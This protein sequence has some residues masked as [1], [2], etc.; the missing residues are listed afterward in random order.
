M[1]LQVRGPPKKQRRGSLFERCESMLLNAIDAV[2]R[3][4][5][6]EHNGGPRSDGSCGKSSHTEFGDDEDSEDV[7]AAFA[8]Y[9]TPAREDVTKYAF[10][11]FKAHIEKYRGSRV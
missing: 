10:Q 6:D 3:K 11:E 7:D 5:E 8:E 4:E 9:L 1:K 2:G